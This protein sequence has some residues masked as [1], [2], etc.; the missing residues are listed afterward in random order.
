MKLR[1]KIYVLVSNISG[2]LRYGFKV[3]RKNLGQETKYLMFP[4]RKEAIEFGLQ[5]L[6]R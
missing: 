1:R 2:R 4:T 5:Y 6:N 3:G